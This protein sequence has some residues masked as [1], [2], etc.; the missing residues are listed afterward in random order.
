MSSTTYQHLEKEGTYLTYKRG[1]VD[2]KVKLQISKYDCS[3]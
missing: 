1:D 2:M 3:Y